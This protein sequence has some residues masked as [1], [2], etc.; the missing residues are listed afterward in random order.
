MTNPAN[1]KKK[2]LARQPPSQPYQVGYGKP[3]AHSRFKPGQSGNPSGRPKGAKNKRL[4]LHEERL[5]SIILEEAYRFIKVSDG[6]R[7]VSIPMA[8]AVIRS[9]AV[10]AARGKPACPAPVHRATRCHRNRQQ[11]PLR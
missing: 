10:N 9:L 6:D 2:A 7:P 11:A 5:K 8:Q 3:P 1:S 4:A